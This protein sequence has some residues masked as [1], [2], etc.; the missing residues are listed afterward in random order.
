MDPYPV[1]IFSS[2][3]T[4]TALRTFVVTFDVVKSL[5]F[6][7]THLDVSPSSASFQK[8]SF[9]PRSFCYKLGRSVKPASVNTLTYIIGAP[10]IGEMNES[11]TP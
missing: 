10:E 3:Y 8:L 1:R 5:H 2:P 6:R 11:L 4:L 9:N 7:D